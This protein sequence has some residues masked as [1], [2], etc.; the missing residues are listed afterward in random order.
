MQGLVTV[1]GGSGFVGRYVVQQ[2]AAAGARVRVGV[3][4]PQAALFLK[5]LGQVGQIQL[6]QTD[7]RDERQLAAAFHG[8]DAGVNLVGILAEGGGRTFAGIQAE[9]AA[10]A[11]RVAAGAGARTYVHMSAIGADAASL[12]AYGR[13]K[14]EGEAAVLAALPAAT[15][16][17]PSLIFGAED[18]FTNRFAALARSA[19]VMP[20]VEGETRFQP[21][22]VVDVARAVVASLD[23]PARYGGAAFELGGP[24]IYT[25]RQLLAWIM[26][27]IRVDKPMVDVP[28]L[29]ARLIARAGRFAARPADHQRSPA[30]APPRQCGRRGRA[31]AGGL[32]HRAHPHG[33]GR[34]AVAGALS[35]LRPLQRRA[36]DARRRLSAPA[37]AAL[38]WRSASGSYRGCVPPPGVVAHEEACRSVATSLSPSGAISASS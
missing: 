33:S 12:S 15:I 23:T 20:V 29:A 35:S 14:A 22:H 27:E 16:L 34:A 24:T 31:G 32:P 9:G 7:V 3:R 5:P 30:D 6:I 21:V 38:P 28:A 36:G 4:R 37:R 8:A 19:P 26:R 11:A 2:L 13:S 25:M 1:I 10:T 18:G 17:R